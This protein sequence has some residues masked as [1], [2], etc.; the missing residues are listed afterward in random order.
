MTTSD[1]EPDCDLPEVAGIITGA[2]FA[3]DLL[4]AEYRT[5]RDEILKKMDHRTSLVVCS[6][7]VSSAV[8]GFGIER[9]S[10][11]LLL[12]SP[13]VSLLLG[14]L[15]VFYNMQ[16]GVASEYL[17]KRYEQPLSRRFKGFIGWHEGMGDP[18]IRLF[19]RLVPYHLPL[20]LI[21]IAPVIVAVPLAA[22]L[23]SAFVAG[24]PVLVVVVCLFAVYLFELVKNRK[25]L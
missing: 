21:A 13:L 11:S 7:T 12:V 25:L 9:R 20:I 15:I 23:G 24:L 14:I 17:R 18:N 4:L 22:A 19:Q 6:V 3:G 16:I 1:G 2:E 10:A 5:L 8:L